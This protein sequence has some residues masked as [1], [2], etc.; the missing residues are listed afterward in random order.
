MLNYWGLTN[1]LLLRVFLGVSCVSNCW[2]ANIW[3]LLSLITRPSM[4]HTCCSMHVLWDILCLCTR[5]LHAHWHALY[6]F[7][8]DVC[9]TLYSID[10][11]RWVSI[12]FGIDIDNNPLMNKCMNGQLCKQWRVVSDIITLGYINIIMALITYKWTSGSQ[13]M[14]TWVLHSLVVISPHKY[15]DNWIL[16]YL[17]PWVIFILHKCGFHFCI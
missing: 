17:D 15:Q 5:H 7:S 2:C 6:Q 12:I 16:A 1:A 4:Y 14:S 3:F 10:G 11:Q 13:S 8:D 9:A